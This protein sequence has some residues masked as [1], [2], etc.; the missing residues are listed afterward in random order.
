M[1]W[2]EIPLPPS[3]DDSHHSRNQQ[4]P[5]ARLHALEE[6][7]FRRAMAP[8]FPTDLPNKPE[9]ESKTWRYCAVAGGFF[10]LL[11][12][13]IIWLSVWV[14]QLRSQTA[15]L[16]APAVSG[17]LPLADLRPSTITATQTQTRSTTLMR[18]YYNTSTATTTTV[19]TAVTTSFLVNTTFI[20]QTT[21]S[22]S[23]NIVTVTA[24]EVNQRSTPAHTVTPEPP[25]AEIVPVSSGCT[26]N[27]SP[28]I[29][30]EFCVF[31]DS[32]NATLASTPNICKNLCLTGACH[33]PL[34]TGKQ[35]CCGKCG[36]L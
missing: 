17:K 3:Y 20:T 18:T 25:P 5:E 31:I 6:L 14:S 10:L 24:A 30:T 32:C 1:G 36:C 8:P 21:F 15:V 27:G 33:G 2:E 9:K 13:I 11:T 26:P 22:I 19:S 23:N 4:S 35:S 34:D 16:A 7:T 28:A 12:A 29:N